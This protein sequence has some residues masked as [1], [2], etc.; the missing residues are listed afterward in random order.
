MV[1]KVVAKGT[2]GLNGYTLFSKKKRAALTTEMGEEKAK[3]FFIAEGGVTKYVPKLWSALSADEQAKW[4]ADAKEIREDT[5]PAPEATEASAPVG[6]TNLWHPFQKA[7]P[8]YLAAEK[9][10]VPFTGLATATG[11]KYQELKKIGPQ[12]IL[13]FIAKYPALPKEKKAKKGA[14][15]VSSVP[16]EI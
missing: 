8:A 6:K 13:D 12:A 2:G 1:A 14:A 9:I 10:A 4:N 3:V 16:V 5:V 7:F 11:E 15:A